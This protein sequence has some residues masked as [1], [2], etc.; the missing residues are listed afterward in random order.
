VKFCGG[1]QTEIAH[2]GE[3]V[4][5]QLGMI[6]G[7]AE[8]LDR[9]DVAGPHTVIEHKGIMS[10]EG[11]N[12]GRGKLEHLYGRVAYVQKSGFGGVMADRPPIA[13]GCW[14]TVASVDCVVSTV[15]AEDDPTGDCEVV[16]DPKRPTARNARWNGGA[17]DFLEPE[18]FGINAKKAPRLTAYVQALRGRYSAS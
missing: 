5:G 3:Y 14:I 15:R 16:F 4:G 12:G 8:V 10:P 1:Q 17:W 9:R 11:R 7:Y 6:S 2:I 18:D 13:H